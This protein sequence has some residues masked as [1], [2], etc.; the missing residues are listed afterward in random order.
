MFKVSFYIPDRG[1]EG[2][3]HLRKVWCHQSQIGIFLQLKLKAFFH[4]LHMVNYPNGFGICKTHFSPTF[5]S[6]PK[7]I[8]ISLVGKSCFM[9]GIIPSAFASD[10]STLFYAYSSHLQRKKLRLA[11]VLSPNEFRA[12]ISLE[13]TWKIPYLSAAM[14]NY[15]YTFARWCWHPA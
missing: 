1:L 12:I 14:Y 3:F 15:Y 9:P 7:D 2:N 13:S 10:L 11:T 6:S 5:N 8:T 4:S